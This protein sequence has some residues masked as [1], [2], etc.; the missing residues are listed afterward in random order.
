MEEIEKKINR[1]ID[2]LAQSDAV[3]VSYINNAI[4]CR[5]EQRSEL[6]EQ[7]AKGKISAR[8]ETRR[9]QFEPLEFEQKKLVAEQ[10]IWEIRLSDDAV[11]VM[12]N[13]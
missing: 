9:L 2:A 8:S 1:L 10:F 4:K 6:L 5:D 3:S 13:V 12:W 11:N 7:F